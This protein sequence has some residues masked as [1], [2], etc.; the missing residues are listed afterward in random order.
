M[1]IDLDRLSPTERMSL[2][3]W[4]PELRRIFNCTRPDCGGQ[5]INGICLLCAT[6]YENG[7]PVGG[8]P[9]KNINVLRQAKRK[10]P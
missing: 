5:V 2:L 4:R 10:G 8:I 3:H 9:A 1:T 7:E 6:E